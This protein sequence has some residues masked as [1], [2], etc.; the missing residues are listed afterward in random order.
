MERKKKVRVVLYFFLTLYL[1]VLCLII[2]TTDTGC[3]FKSNRQLHQLLLSSSE[4]CSVPLSQ[5][6]RK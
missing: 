2:A 5:W 1:L 4:I 6:E 3:L